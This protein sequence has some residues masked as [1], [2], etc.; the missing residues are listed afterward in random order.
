[1]PH[2]RDKSVFA[3]PPPSA[4]LQQQ[5]IHEPYLISKKSGAGLSSGAFAVS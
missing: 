1:M 5:F 2:Q 4:L 3:Y